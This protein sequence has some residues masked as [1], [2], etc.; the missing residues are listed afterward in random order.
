MPSSTARGAR[1]RR[2]RA[3]LR[4]TAD[5]FGSVED[6][7]VLERLRENLMKGEQTYE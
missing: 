4:V 1:K 7:I 6:A 5:P 2:H 3:T